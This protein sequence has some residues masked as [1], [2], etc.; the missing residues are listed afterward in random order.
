M[1]AE[2][3]SKNGAQKSGSECNICAYSL[4]AFTLDNIWTP[5]KYRQQRQRT[6]E[7]SRKGPL[8]HPGP[9]QMEASILGSLTSWFCQREIESE[10]AIV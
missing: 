2:F 5:S 4:T 6:A 7:A 10:K 1:W 9:S 8:L 3:A